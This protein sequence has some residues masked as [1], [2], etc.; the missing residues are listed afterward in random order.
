MKFKALILI[1]VL[2][3]SPVIASDHY[4]YENAEKLK[5]LIEW[6]DYGP[7]AFEEALKEN[8]PIFL[9]LTAPTWCYWCQ[10]Y[11]SE[12]YLF[13]QDVYNYINENFIPIYVDADKRQDLTRQYLEGGWPST[14]IFSPSFE[15]IYGYSGPRPVQNMLTNLKQA[16][17]FVN[18]KE[19]SKSISY[20]YTP[21]EIVIPNE[22]TLD[23]LINIYNSYTLQLYDPVY[24]G[25][26]TGQKFPQGRTLDFSL[27]MYESTQD[28][29]FLEIVQNTL[30]NQY[31]DISEI[32]T[33]YN[34]FDPIEGGFHRYGTRRE[35]TPPHYE[36]MLYDNARL[37]KAYAH[38]LEITPEDAL[39]K[40]VVKKTK[41]YI[42]LNWYDKENGGFYGNTDVHGEDE[43]YGKNPRPSD[44]PRVEKTKYTNWNSE[45][46]LTYLYLWQ[47]SKEERYRTIAE[48]SLDF[49]SEQAITKT[50]TYHYITPDGKKGV[51]GNLL[52]NSY[53]IL[54]FV[55][56]YEV[57]G[58][59]KYLENAQKLADYTLENLY[60]WNSG[61]FF[62]RNS[63]DKDLYAPGENVLLTKPGEENGI[64][65]YALS[66]L[67]KQ[68]GE[69]S[70]LNAAIKTIGP[71][72]SSVGGTD[73]GYYYIKASQFILENELLSDFDKF[74]TEI[75]EL[76]ENKKNNFWLNNILKEE[77][78]ISN[79]GLRN[80]SGPLTL[81]VLISL[82]AG[83]MSFIS[84]CTLPILP[85]YLAHTF[86]SSKKNIRS[87]TI[88]MFLGLVLIFTL[89]GMGA[90][91]VG[92]FLKN[93]ISFF[94]KIT[95]SVIMLFGIYI[96]A[97]KGFSGFAIKQEKPTSFFGAFLFG[98]ALGLSWTPCVGPILVAILLIASTTGSV[99]SG[100]LLLFFYGIGLAFPL[101]LLSMYLEKIDT[102]SKIWK[103][104]NGKQIIIKYGQKEFSIHSST[105][106]SG[107]LFLIIGYLIFS[108]TLIVF[109]QYVSAT[110]LQKWVF[111]IEE[112]ILNWLN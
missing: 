71:R 92:S 50:G 10:V 59:E 89:L 25:F 7:V 15:R 64:M 73:R 70:Y 3:C 81:L 6:R 58:N 9:L 103:V 111:G 51:R 61:G 37:L 95:G 85:A 57:L 45:A 77:F 22:Y 99:F 11:E 47:T 35:W 79:E 80:I 63:P 19:F 74:K 84:P 16:V 55:E 8:K 24:G 27:E 30:A 18:S 68:T 101:I 36:K 91:F 52:D 56:G 88:A 13:H 100:G 23:S 5:P 2:L 94:S 72:I 87:M 107:L 90:T 86:R 39:V 44:K 48:K 28:I 106:I 75:E 96:L 31:T 17:S 105:L 46:I 41:E 82:L 38:L 108:G 20:D 29:K 21:T 93:N 62:E 60:D 4:T 40:E 104:L 49:Y 110:S 66:K 14:T 67:Y 98:A 78:T 1:F 109:N 65:A 53:L 34:L 43:Y 33:N 69:I 112:W 32:E 76:E 102:S 83:L 26:G 97:G 12:D 54:A 42:E